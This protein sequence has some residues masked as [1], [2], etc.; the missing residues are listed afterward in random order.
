MTVAPPVST[1]V[2]LG[3]VGVDT[4]TDELD[5]WA[6]DVLD[7]AVRHV[8]DDVIAHTWRRAVTRPGDHRGA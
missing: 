3:G 8:P 6:K 1:Y 7:E 2:T 5:K 4:M